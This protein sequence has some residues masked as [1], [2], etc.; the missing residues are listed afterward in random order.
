MTGNS[1]IHNAGGN[2]GVGT[3]TPDVSAKLEIS[4]T[5]QGVLPP[6]L[7]TAQ[8]LSIAGP[9]DGLLVYN[10]ELKCFYGYA[11][12]GWQAISWLHPI[13]P[14]HPVVVDPIAGTMRYAPKGWFTQ[15]SPAD[16][17]CR[18]S[19]ETQF[20]HTLTRAFAV[21]ETEVTRQMWATLLA[22]QT[23]L[24]ADPTNTAYG[25]GLGHPVQNLSWYEAVL[26]ANLLSVERGLT[27]CY[28][29]DGD[30]TTPI[31]AS[32]YTSGPFYCDWAADG[33]RLPSSGEW[34]YFCRAGTTTPFWIAEPSYSISYCST[35]VAGR[36]PELETAA[37]FCANSSGGTAAVA[38]KAPNPWGIYDT[39]GNVGEWCW[40]IDETYPAGYATDYRGAAS[41][42]GRI[43]RPACWDYRPNECRS[44][45]FGAGV[46]G[47]RH[48][49]FG[50]RL[51]RTLD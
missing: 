15:G 41:G 35:C 23:S 31:D 6:R 43:T 4:S 50:F 39:H 37:V 51:V 33:F 30:F 26:F 16:E 9:A 44:A 27:R 21:M 13:I 22:V 42:S 40:D 8:M 25:A 7:T 46:P 38:T 47:F 24:P 20:I 45:S 1:N 49:H 3:A 18:A 19:T 29:A 12:T 10:T 2:V 5:S 14:G 36:H 48:P 34:E 17:P 11:G 32:N 28:W